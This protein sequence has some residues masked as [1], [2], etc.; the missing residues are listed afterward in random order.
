[1]QGDG[2]HFRVGDLDAKALFDAE[3]A[4][5]SGE[6]LCLLAGIVEALGG[7]LNRGPD[8]VDQAKGAA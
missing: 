4:L 5:M 1:M 2:C 8:L 3:F 7:E 6:L